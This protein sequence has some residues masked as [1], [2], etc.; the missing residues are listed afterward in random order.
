[1]YRILSLDGGGVRGL[2]T[3]TLLARLEEAIPGWRQEVNLITGSSTGGIIAIALAAGATPQELV[4]LYTNGGR[5]IFA[6]SRRRRW[7]GLR[8][9][10]RAGYDNKNLVRELRRRLGDLTL[11]DLPHKVLVPAFQLDDGHPNP[12]ERRWRTRFFHNFDES[13]EIPAY[14]VA[15]YTS[16][17]PTYFPTVDG[18]ADGGVFA[19]HPGAAALTWVQAGYVPAGNTEPLSETVLLSLGTGSEYVHIEGERHDWGLL[20]WF[21]LLLNMIRDSSVGLVEYQCQL[22]LQERYHRLAPRLEKAI[23][24]DAWSECC[25]LQEVGQSVAIDDTVAWLRTFWGTNEDGR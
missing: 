18:F 1:M 11:S 23:P 8:G 12:R 20:R 13:G 14:K 17:S 3:V 10:L 7:L 9:L 2:M 15:L 25:L 6:R 22:L 24:S 21:P 16:A 5:T 4:S 19:Y